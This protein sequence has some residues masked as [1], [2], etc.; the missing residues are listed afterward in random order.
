MD[1]N[2]FPSAADLIFAIAAPVTAI[3]GAVKLTQADGDLSAHIRMG[4]LILATRHIPSHSLASYTA[5]AEPMVG[6]AWLAEIFF[7]TLFRIGGLPL[8]C[9]FA[10]IVV[11]TTH[12]AI[13]LFLR[14][15]GVDPRW[16][17][18]AA[19]LSFALAS[20]HWLARPHLFSIVGSAL[21]LFLLESERRR[22]QL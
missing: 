10:G 8:I 19:L 1:R 3:V 4:N 14:R 15:R 12:G 7:A 2:N 9:V 13:A 16:A 18:A 5:A 20:T 22:R 11:G 21:T 6:H 17:F